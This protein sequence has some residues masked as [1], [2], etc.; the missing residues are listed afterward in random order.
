MNYKL[1]R[2]SLTTGDKLYLNMVSIY[3]G[4]LLDID[5]H[6]GRYLV[7]SEEDL[8]YIQKSETHGVFLVWRKTEKIILLKDLIALINTFEEV[9][10]LPINKSFKQSFINGVRSL[11]GWIPGKTLT[12]ECQKIMR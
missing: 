2:P 10:V 12:E 8:A 1:I 11:L 7:K 4:Y 5:E 6:K 3:M 9:D